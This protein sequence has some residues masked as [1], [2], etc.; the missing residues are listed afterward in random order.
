MRTDWWLLALATAWGCSPSAVDSTQLDD[1]SIQQTLAGHTMVL[2]K[3]F[4]IGVYAQ[5]LDGVRLMVLGPDGAVYASDVDGNKIVKLTDADHNGVAEGITTVHSGLNQPH[6]MAFRGDTLYVAETDQVVRFP[7]ATSSAQVVVPDIPTGGHSTRTIVFVGDTMYLSVGSSCNICDEG[8]QR[9]AAVTSYRPDGSSQQVFARG[10][11]NSVGLAVHP[12]TKEIWATNNDRDSFGCGSGVTCDQS[13]NVPPDRVNILQRGGFYG[14]PNCYLPGKP[15]P[16]YSSNQGPCANAIG[17]AV[18]LGAHVAPLGLT[19]YT[20]T[21]FP[22]AYRGGLFI[23]EHGSW[24]RTSGAGPVG[25][26]VEWVPVSNGKPSGEA[27]RFISGWLEGSSSWGRPV[28][29]LTMPDGALLISDDAS[30][31]IYRVTYTG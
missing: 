10:L 23:A 14:W 16:E 29:V 31:R 2:P 7:S 18:Q 21:A 13:D 20:G 30:G 28:D 5:G 8:D 12:S 1:Q 11:R 17:P 19:F 26:K 25:Y 15:N 24:N 4:S 9:R 6:G 22:E 3:G 27:R